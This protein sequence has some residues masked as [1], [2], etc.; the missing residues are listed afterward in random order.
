M[1]Q[2]RPIQEIPLATSMTRSPLHACGPETDLKAAQEL[3]RHHQVRRLPVVDAEQRV[4]GVL[5]LN[6]LANRAA[7]PRGNP[8]PHATPADIG[9]TLARIGEPHDARETGRSAQAGA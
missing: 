3:M 7:L 9:A 4:V 5:S 8:P 2:G 1:T 6:D